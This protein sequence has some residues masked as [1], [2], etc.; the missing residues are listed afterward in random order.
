MQP[1]QGSWAGDRRTAGAGPDREPGTSPRSAE[2]WTPSSRAWSSAHSPG[3]ARCSATAHVRAPHPPARPTTRR[4]WA[5]VLRAGK[6][7]RV[8]GGRLGEGVVTSWRVSRG[9]ASTDSTRSLSV[10]LC[11]QHRPTCYTV[12]ERAGGGDSGRS[13]C[14]I[15]NGLGLV[16]RST[17]S[18][19]HVGHR[20]SRRANRTVQHNRLYDTDSCI[21]CRVSV[22]S[23]SRS[24]CPTL[25]RNESLS[26]VVA[27]FFAN[28][29]TVVYFGATSTWAFF[30]AADCLDDSRRGEVGAIADPA[31]TSPHPR[32]GLAIHPPSAESWRTPVRSLRQRIATAP[33][34]EATCAAAHPSVPRCLNSSGVEQ[35]VLSGP[36]PWS[37]PHHHH[38]GDVHHPED[39]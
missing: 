39:R 27:A 2:T 6:V 23:V 30:P 16:E 22:A 5:G 3:A 29:R 20:P 35:P 1:D 26:L 38:L 7:D 4:C 9:H 37:D 24:R 17:H 14:T 18:V 21:V 32:R 15:A 10:R 36:S 19:R 13:P 31:Y 28:L 34:S 25:C 33:R 12:D 8:L 11:A